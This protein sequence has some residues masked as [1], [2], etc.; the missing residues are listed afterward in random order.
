MMNTRTFSLLPI[1]LSLLLLAVIYGCAPQ[2]DSEPLQVFPATVNQDCAPWDGGAFTIMIPYNAVSTIQIS[3][4][5]L[6]DPDHRSTFSFPD[7]TGRV[8]HAALH[9]SST[10]TLG[11]TVSLSAVEEGRPLEGEF[12]LFT[13]AGKRLRGKFIAAWGDFVALCG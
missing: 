11:G 9:A 5:D 3:I 7:E 4:W 1:S 13:E 12:D 2:N 6:S 8:G 10:E